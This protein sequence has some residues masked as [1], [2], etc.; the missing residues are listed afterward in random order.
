MNG[1]RFLA[2]GLV[3]SIVGLVACSSDDGATQSENANQPEPC[4]EAK[5][6]ADECN[7]KPA[8]DGAKI[9]AD[10]DTAKCQSSGEQG[11]KAAECIVTNKSNCD[12]LLQCALTGACS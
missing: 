5:K 7:A 10:F 1:I 6:V 2:I 4:A 11:K 3:T 12:C 9:T 8:K